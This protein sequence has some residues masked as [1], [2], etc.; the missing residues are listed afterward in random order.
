MINF[1]GANYT[2]LVLEHLSFNSKTLNLSAA[3]CNSPL[4]VSGASKIIDVDK[5]QVEYLGR[6]IL[7]WQLAH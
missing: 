7:P 4:E 5:S 6:Q 3:L 1:S 2:N